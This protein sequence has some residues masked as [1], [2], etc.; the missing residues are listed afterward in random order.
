VCH[1][2]PAHTRPAR[3]QVAR[4]LSL[5]RLHGTAGKIAVGSLQSVHVVALTNLDR[6]LRSNTRTAGVVALD[7]P[8]LSGRW[9]WSRCNSVLTPP[10]VVGSAPGDRSAAGLPVRCGSIVT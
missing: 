8:A 10:C 9:W 6:A 7:D 4:K 2:A 5:V 3:E 1:S